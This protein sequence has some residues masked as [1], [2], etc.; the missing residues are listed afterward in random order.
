MLLRRSGGDSLFASWRFW[1]GLGLKSCIL[2]VLRVWNRGKVHCIYR[3]LGT[4]C[5]SV[6]CD[7]VARA[8]Y[9]WQALCLSNDIVWIRRLCHSAHAST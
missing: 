1:Y 4:C 7:E 9:P 6:L 8:G 3:L 5:F 2:V